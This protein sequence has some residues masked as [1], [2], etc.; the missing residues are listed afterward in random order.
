MRHYLVGAALGAS[1]ILLLGAAG[2]VESR[3][4]GLE[5][6]KKDLATRLSALETR[7]S[8]LEKQVKTTGG[9]G[10][11]TT[12]TPPDATTPKAAD[13][14]TA[15]PA[16]E[17]GQ[18]LKQTIKNLTTAGYKEVENL[19]NLWRSPIEL[20]PGTDPDPSKKNVRGVMGV[21]KLRYIGNEDYKDFDL[22]IRLLYTTKGG[23]KTLGISEFVVPGE[24]LTPE[25]YYTYRQ[26]T[27]LSEEY[28]ASDEVKVIFLSKTKASSSSRH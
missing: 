9:T 26:F 14:P 5:Q 16:V 24:L 17:E 13:D 25:R 6:G 2:D 1:L 20:K 21:G 3:I 28:V 18:D 23:A 4:A 7:V 12:T 22:K 8:A 10:S 19:T 27:A 15:D 11:A